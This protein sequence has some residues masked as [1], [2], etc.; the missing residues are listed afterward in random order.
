MVLML[1]E[2]WELMMAGK[3]VVHLAETRVDVQVEMLAD[4]KVVTLVDALV[5]ATAVM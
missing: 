5:D 3:T 4:E 1:V 2:M